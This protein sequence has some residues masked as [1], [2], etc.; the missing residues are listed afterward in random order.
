MKAIKRIT[1][2]SNSKTISNGERYTRRSRAKGV[3]IRGKML[4]KIR[5]AS[6][7][8]VV[9]GLINRVLKLKPKLEPLRLQIKMWE[10]LTQCYNLEVIISIQIYYS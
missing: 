6:Y 8:I 3:S 5:N 2:I 1:D 4:L 9:R 7:I 10:R